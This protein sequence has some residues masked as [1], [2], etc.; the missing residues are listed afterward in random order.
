MCTFVSKKS[1]CGKFNLV[2]GN[3]VIY[4]NFFQISYSFEFFNKKKRKR[5]NEERE[6]VMYPVCPPLQPPI[7]ARSV[8]HLPWQISIY[9]VLVGCSI[10]VRSQQAAVELGRMVKKFNNHKPSLEIGK[11]WK[12]KMYIHCS[13]KLQGK[14][15]NVM[16]HFFIF[17]ACKAAS[18]SRI[19]AEI[20][21]FYI[22]KM[23]RT[24]IMLLFLQSL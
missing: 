21:V 24:R 20:C 5:K 17:K 10:C 3:V 8:E 13:Q 11:M 2:E 4:Y 9:S 15:D 12:V 16:E 18:S 6:G 19:M 23:K 1:K 14:N 7:P 22:H